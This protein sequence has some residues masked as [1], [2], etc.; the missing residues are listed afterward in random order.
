VLDDEYFPFIAE[1]GDPNITW[2]EVQ[3]L[4]AKLPNSLADDFGRERDERF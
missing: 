2:E 4:L 1:D 3:L